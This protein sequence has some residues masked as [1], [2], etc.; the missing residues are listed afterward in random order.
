MDSP[1]RPRRMDPGRVIGGSALNQT[2]SS[3]DNP[4]TLGSAVADQP[5]S[6]Q[7]VTSWTGQSAGKD[8]Q[9][10]G[11]SVATPLSPVALR[12]ERPRR[13]PTMRATL[14]S[15][16]PLR[17]LRWPAAAGAFHGL[18]LPGMTVRP[19]RMARTLSEGER[20][21]DRKRKANKHCGARMK[22]GKSKTCLI[23]RR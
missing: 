8:R 12:I 18:K 14:M 5:K 10:A 3:E 9:A 22:D 13:F 6:R 23:S 15:C 2:W 19:D 16:W 4:E 17:A 1:R 20:E 21:S 11:T 7:P